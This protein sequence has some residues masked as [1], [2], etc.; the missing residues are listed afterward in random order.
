MKNESVKRPSSAQPIPPHAKEV[1]SG[2]LFKVYQWEQKMYDGSVRI[3][4]KLK[5]PDTVVIFPVLDD[6]RII[7]IE[8]E[9]PAI[10][11]PKIGTP[12]G[13]VDEG[14]DILVAAKRELRE[15]TGYEAEEFILWHAVHPT[16]KLDWVVYTFI[17][18][19]LKK[20]ADQELDGGERVTLK[21]ISFD[22]MVRIGSS[23]SFSEKESIPKFLEARADPR[24]M[25]ELKVLFKPE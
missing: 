17:A 15:E 7:L 21:P 22:E 16:I 9:Q 12:S 10:T 5:R 2:I 4:E 3:F 18:K 1:F 6:G 14:E 19:G 24:K 23:G 20:V 11:H 8:E 25:E 13:R